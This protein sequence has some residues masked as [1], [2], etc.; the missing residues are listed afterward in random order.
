[1]EARAIQAVFKSNLDGDRFAFSSTK[2]GG[3]SVWWQ[4][5]HPQATV[6]RPKVAHLTSRTV[7]VQQ[8]ATGH[9]LGAA[10]AVEAIFSVLALHEVRGFQDPNCSLAPQFVL[11]MALVVRF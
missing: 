4:S 2:V 3:S 10:G 7:C 9:L 1:M 11:V 6:V 5:R 8:G